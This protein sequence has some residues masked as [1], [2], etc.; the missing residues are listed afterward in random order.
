MIEQS[1]V[2]GAMAER[3]EVGGCGL[4]RRDRNSAVEPRNKSKSKHEHY[5][6]PLQPNCSSVLNEEFI[7]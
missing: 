5:A 3:G 6:C 4:C 1:E 2:I 7:R